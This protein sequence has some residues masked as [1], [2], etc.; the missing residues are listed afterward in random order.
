MQDKEN[1]KDMIIEKYK[2]EINAAIKEL[3][4][5]GERYRQIPNILTLSRLLS[6]LLI[7]P[8]AATGNVPLTIG[9]TAA[10]GFTDFVDGQIARTYNL[11]SKLGADLDAITD[12]IF[13]GTIL[14]AASFTNP[15]LLMN[16]GL[17]GLIS[18]VN[19]KSKL[20]GENPKSLYIGKAKTWFLFGLSAL[21]IAGTAIDAGLIGAFSIATAIMQAQTLHAYREEYNKKQKTNKPLVKQE[22]QEI[23]PEQKITASKELAK[24]KTIRNKI[25]EL[26][27]AKK[28]LLEGKT[29]LEEKPK[30][31][32]KK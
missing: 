10:F 27:E 22:K 12:K 8:A 24:E 6:P 19:I 23:Q 1:I 28:E 29:I 7:L 13:G 2:T 17:E 30:Q 16:L 3:N 9:L 15:I 5:P 11:Q 26:E 32:T 20:E 18:A 21:G 14:L 25:E 4:T 31:Y